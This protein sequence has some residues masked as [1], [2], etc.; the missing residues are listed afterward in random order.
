MIF[1]M[2]IAIYS[3]HLIYIIYT[4]YVSYLICSMHVSDIIYAV[5]IMLKLAV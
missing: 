5:D 2:F 3:F 1:I 4:A